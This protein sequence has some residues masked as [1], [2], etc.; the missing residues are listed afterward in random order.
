MKKNIKDVVRETITEY[1]LIE[2]Y[3][4]ISNGAK[5]ISKWYMKEIKSTVFVWWYYEDANGKMCD[6]SRKQAT[7]LHYTAEF[8]VDIDTVHLRNTIEIANTDFEEKGTEKMFADF[9]ELIIDP[10]S[11]NR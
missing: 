9:K 4:G 3:D 10:I 11:E 2:H 6:S 1:M 7:K 8:D 5:F